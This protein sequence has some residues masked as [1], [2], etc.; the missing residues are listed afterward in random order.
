MYSLSDL[1]ATLACFLCLWVW[2]ILFGV[3][4]CNCKGVVDEIVFI[5]LSFQ[6]CEVYRDTN[7]IHAVIQKS[8]KGE[9]TLI[10][11]EVCSGLA[12]CFKCSV[13]HVKR[14]SRQ[15]SFLGGM[16]LSNS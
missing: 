7:V 10:S 13:V 14:D 11:A 6:I 15:E 1:V 5:V 2:V 12:L 8:L 4:V 3:K 16:W 9:P